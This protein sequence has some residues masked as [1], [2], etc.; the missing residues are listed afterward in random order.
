VLAD[1]GGEQFG[2][3]TFLARNANTTG[4]FLFIITEG[5]AGG[6]V[7]AHF[8]ARHFENFL[9][10]DGETLG[11]AHGKAVPLHMG[12]YFQA[13]PRNLHGFRLNQAYNR[14]AAFLTPG[15]FESF[16]TR[17][18][19]LTARLCLAAGMLI[20]VPGGPIASPAQEQPEVRMRT[21]TYASRDGVDLVLDLYLPAKPIRRPVPVIVFLHGGG[22]SGGTRTTGP[23]FKRFFAQDGMAMA[24]IEYRL[25]P[26]VTFPANVEDVRTAVRWLKANAPAYDLDPRRICLWGTSAGGHLATVAALAP[27]GTFEG[28]G[29]LDQT[30]DVRCVLDAYG[31]T[32]FDVMDAQTENER[33]ALQKPVVSGGLAPGVGSRGADRGASP[34]APAGQTSPRSPVPHD[35]PT[36][37]ESRLLGAPV[38]TVPDRVR[39]ASPLAY[40]GADAPPFLIMH[41]LADS[42]VPHGQ[43]VLLYDALRAAGRTVTLRLIDGLPH[44]F[45][46]ITDLDAA[47]P[48]RMQVREQARGGAE[49]VR[50]ERAGA[51][52]VAREF[53]RRHLE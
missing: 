37:P 1:G 49:S 17:G 9:G 19:H 20:A 27:R 50:T 53:F 16:F 8:H 44:T 33:P 38:Q 48:F 40:V 31:P 7:G 28:S 32:R 39:A 41:G 21:L 45:F 24:S 30:S 15:I 5:G 46:N 34:A 10:L 2:G 51:F 12:D 52:D 6:G 36:S 42:S 18:L 11:W 26:A 3:N 29:N 14:F 22:W 35:A 4:Q 43:S 25:T 13:P 47:G 23:D